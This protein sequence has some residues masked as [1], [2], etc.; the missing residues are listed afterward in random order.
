MAVQKIYMTSAEV[1]KRLPVK[2]SRS[3][4]R[5]YV[6]QGKITVTVENPRRW[7]YHR[8]SVEE[9]AKSFEQ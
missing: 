8:A 5:A 3:A 1:R 6:A 4:L 9:F 7:L 2:I